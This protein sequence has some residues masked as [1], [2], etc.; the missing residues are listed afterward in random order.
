MS[1]IT[2]FSIFVIDQLSKYFLV[3]WLAIGA[4]YPLTPF[5]SIVH[6]RNYG[7]SF[8]M[9]SS[10]NL[11]WWLIAFAGVIISYILWL[12]KKA[13]HTWQKITYSAIVG[14]ALGNVADR[15]MRGSVVDFIYF[16]IGP[17]GYPAFNIADS[18]IVCSVGWLVWK[19][20]HDK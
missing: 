13:N 8:S 3:T 11:R 17:Y 12:W 9:L 20:W 2:C 16:H 19:E 18:A 15:L 4:S 5:F 6:A 1:L 10:Y 7:V 14:G